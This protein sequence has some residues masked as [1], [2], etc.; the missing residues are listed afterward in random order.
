[1]HL[2]HNNENQHG[3]IQHKAKIADA[4]M[5]KM[6][7]TPADS[8]IDV[9]SGDGYYSSKF[10]EHCEKVLAIE[11][12][13]AS[14]DSAFYKNPNITTLDVDACKWILNADL[15]AF[16][17]IFFSNS[18]HDIQCQNKMLLLFAQQLPNGA[19]LNLIE[20]KP[21]TPFGPPRHIRFSKEELKSTIEAYGFKE[22]AYIDLN[23]HYFV[24]LKLVK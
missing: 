4:I 8:L 18:F 23:T 1:M 19:H 22:D 21:D 5:E 24:S 10:A 14:F 7:L 20:F 6:N 15:R 16:T 17:H 3:S 9:G 2:F 12:F 11:L 13:S